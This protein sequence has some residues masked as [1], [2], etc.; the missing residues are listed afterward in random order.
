VE[1]QADKVRAV[2]EWPVPKNVTE[3]RAY[4][5]T[6]GYYRRF[7]P[8]FADIAAPLH[9]LL[10]KNVHFEWGFPQQQAFDTLKDRLCCAP[11]LGIPSDAGTFVLDTDASNLGLGAVLS[12]RQNDREVVIAYASR[13]LSHAEGKYDSTKKELLAVVFGLKTFKQYVL[14]RQFV[15]RTDHSALRWLRKTPEPM[16]QLARWLTFTEQF[17]FE[18]QNRS[19]TSHRN[20]DGLSRIPVEDVCVR[21]VETR[22]SRLNRPEGSS[23]VVNSSANNGTNNPT[24]GT[25]T[26]N[27]QTNNLTDDSVIVDV[28]N[29]VYDVV[30]DVN[31]GIVLYQMNRLQT[32]QIR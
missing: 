16:A 15:V 7:I 3:L 32:T 21:A 9:C 11:V 18:I 23:S 14:G 26:D 31:E 2:Q 5:G 30:D 19:G 29:V 22:S 28:D 1:V 25:N 20:A 13:A 17:S 24:T 10:L 12:Q 8:G 27:E 4:L 6:A